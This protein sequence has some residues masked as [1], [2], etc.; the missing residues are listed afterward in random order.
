L[1]EYEP[2][3]IRQLLSLEALEEMVLKTWKM[4]WRWKL[5]KETLDPQFV[6]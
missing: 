6:A 2:L 5:L 3:K 1:S 4:K